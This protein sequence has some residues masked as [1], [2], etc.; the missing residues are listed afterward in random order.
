MW[1]PPECPI[2]LPL[3]HIHATCHAHLIR[4]DLI[5]LIIL[6]EENKF[7]P[8]LCHF[9]PLRSKYSPQHSVL[10]HPPSMFL[11]LK[12]ETKFQTHTEPQAKL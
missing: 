2:C 1:L 10:K 12:S 6:G 11:T 7:S 8:T 5:I 4:L 9:I 3:L